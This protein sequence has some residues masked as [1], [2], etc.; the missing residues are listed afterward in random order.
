M[1]AK[2]IKMLAYMKEP[3]PTYKPDYYS[4][5]TNRANIRFPW[6]ITKDYKRE[7]IKDCNAK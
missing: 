3:Y 7:S 1:G 2:E 6:M 5:E 4:I